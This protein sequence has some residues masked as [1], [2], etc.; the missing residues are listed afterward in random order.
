[1]KMRTIL[2][3]LLA[4][5]CQNAAAQMN[6]PRLRQLAQ[7]PTVNAVFTGFH[8]SQTRGILFGEE[9]ETPPLE[10]I[11]RIRKE[12]KGDA[13]DAERY[14]DLGFLYARTKQKK[15]SA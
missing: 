1:M 14:Q 5:T 8:V 10:E 4:L 11:A 2:L 12:L 7:M 3:A 9:E 6:K 13:S 15:A